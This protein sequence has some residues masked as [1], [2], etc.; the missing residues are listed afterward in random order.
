MADLLNFFAY[1]ADFRNVLLFSFVLR[2]QRICVLFGVG[3]L[4]LEMFKPFHAR[5]VLFELQRRFF[6][7]EL[8]DAPV[9]RVELGRQRVYVRAYHRAGFVD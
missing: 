5:L 7:F 9:R 8:H 4:F 6:N 1:I 3:E 2:A